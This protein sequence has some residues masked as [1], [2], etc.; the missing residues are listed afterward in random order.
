MTPIATTPDY[1]ADFEAFCAELAVFMAELNKEDASADDL[2]GREMVW[3]DFS[4]F[5]SLVGRFKNEGG[6]PDW[7]DPQIG[8]FVD[9][10]RA[11]LESLV[12]IYE[13]PAER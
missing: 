3:G 1:R 8:E 9:A 13:T 11:Y 5:S 7:T 12:E 2:V 10:G 6:G 4:E